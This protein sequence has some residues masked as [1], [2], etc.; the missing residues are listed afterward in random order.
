MA[1]PRAAILGAAGFLG[2]H[3]CER[4]VAE[5]FRV[6]GVDNLVTGVRSNLE[7]LAREP[8][9]ELVEADI[10]DGLERVEGRMPA[11]AAHFSL[12]AFLEGAATS[13]KLRDRITGMQ[14]QVQSLAQGYRET[15]VDVRLEGV[16]LPELLELL[17]AI[18]Q[19]P[20]ALHVRHLQIRPKFDNP[21][22]LDATIRV[23]S[24]AKS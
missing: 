5:G 8:R 6:V 3:L 1:E 23:L 15:A 21:V 2:S 10:C 19:G 9:F 13:A 20:H 4:V 7:A 18:D 22:N 16:Q 14:P 11:S 24:H 17:V 12:L